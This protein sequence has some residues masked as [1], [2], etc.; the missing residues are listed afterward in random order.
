METLN[1]ERAEEI[2][3]LFEVKKT[4]LRRL[5][6]NQYSLAKFLGVNK[7]SVSA[8]GKVYFEDD[9]LFLNK[10]GDFQKVEELGFKNISR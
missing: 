7:N 4:G 6:F 10:L 5:Y 9:T 1:L 8:K 2:G 3:N